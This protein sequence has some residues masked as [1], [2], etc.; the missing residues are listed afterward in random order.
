MAP[1]ADLD[2]LTRGLPNWNG[3]GDPRELSDRVDRLVV[4]ALEQLEL[5][6]RHQLDQ[7]S[8]VR[9]SGAEHVPEGYSDAVAEYYRRLSKSGK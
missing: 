5:Q 9:N 4:P 7:D 8:Q 1:D 6:L 3:L 2:P